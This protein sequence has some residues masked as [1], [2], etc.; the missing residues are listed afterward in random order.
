MEI[1]K[2]EVSFLDTVVRKND[3]ANRHTQLPL[4]NFGTPKHVT[5]NAPYS[6]FL[7][8]RRNC[9]R[10]EDF[11]LE[12]MITDYV[13]RGY[14]A[15][16]VVEHFKRAYSLNRS[17]LLGSKKMNKKQKKNPVRFTTT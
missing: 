16:K 10:D 8:L 9:K 14:N 13:I 2:E 5:N 12:K 7:R 11:L 17:D 6:Q 15:D 4:G 3:K 1:S